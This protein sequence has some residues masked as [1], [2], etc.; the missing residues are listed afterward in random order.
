LKKEDFI[1]YYS[2]L[3]NVELL[4][5]IEEKEKYQSNAIEAANEILSIRNYSNEELS[6]A[7]SEINYVLNKKKEQKEKIEQAKNKVNDFVDEHFGFRE[8]TPE[9]KLNIFCTV[10]FIYT[11]LTVL[12]SLSRMFRHSYFID[13]KFYAIELLSVLLQLLLIYLLYKRNNWGWIGATGLYSFI[14]IS[15]ITSFILY[16]KY[17]NDLFFFRSSPYPSLLS[18]IFCISVVLFLNSRSVFSQFSVENAGRIAT[19]IITLI[20]STIII[21]VPSFI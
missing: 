7:Q 17:K 20:I 11:L 6:T 9:K 14:S 15:S 21:L 8:R 16:F 1:K 2:S 10:L 18:F 12:I 3:T 19:L 13:T 5:I 4:K